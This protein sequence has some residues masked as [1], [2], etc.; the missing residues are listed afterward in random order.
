MKRN[1][2]C[3]IDLGICFVMFAVGIVVVCIFPSE[4]IVVLS[5]IMLIAAGII[6]MKR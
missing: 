2:K 6:L 4:W 1:K 5:A 3:G